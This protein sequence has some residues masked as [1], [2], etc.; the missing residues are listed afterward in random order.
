MGPLISI[1]ADTC[2]GQPR[3]TGTRI[4]V[5]QVLDMLS[6]GYAR[7]HVLVEFPALTDEH[8]TAA[9]SWASELVSGQAPPL[10]VR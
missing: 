7:D 1:D 5:H 4:M 2:G 10:P 9:L 6:A 3:F 8:I